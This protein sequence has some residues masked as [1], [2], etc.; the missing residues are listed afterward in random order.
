[1]QDQRKRDASPEDSLTEEQLDGAVLDFMLDDRSWP[2]SLDELGRE[3]GNRPNA[4]DAVR[5]LTRAGLVH[6]LDGFVFPTRTARRANV[7]HKATA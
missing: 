4:E 1:M 5:R 3:L 6:R 7:V 2:W